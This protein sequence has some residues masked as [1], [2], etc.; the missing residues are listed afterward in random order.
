MMMEKFTNKISLQSILKEL[1]NLMIEDNFTTIG[2]NLNNVIKINKT[3]IINL[4]LNIYSN[5]LLMIVIKISI[6]ILDW[7][8][9]IYN[10][11]FK[12]I[13]MINMGVNHKIIFLIFKK[14]K[15]MQNKINLFVHISK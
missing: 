12:M 7:I 3:I 6:I 1:D 8:E 13:I 2:F 14:G 11:M 15:W 5:H 9:I 10:K 4:G